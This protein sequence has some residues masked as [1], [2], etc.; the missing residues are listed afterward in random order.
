MVAQ[1]N[2]GTQ[3]ELALLRHH[4]RGPLGREDK[5]DERPRN[6]RVRGRLEGGDREGDHQGP[7]APRGLIR[8]DQV[9]WRAGTLLWHIVIVVDEPGSEFALRD[10]IGDIRATVEDLHAVGLEKGGQ[11]CCGCLLAL[12]EDQG[13]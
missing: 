6:V 8:V 12:Q 9:D 13:G 5:V 10:G 2:A 4:R 1:G 7:D 3:R 11:E